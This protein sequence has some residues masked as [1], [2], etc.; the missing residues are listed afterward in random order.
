MNTR[1]PVDP[2]D[3][4]D[5]FDPVGWVSRLPLL[6][7]NGAKS[8]RRNPPSAQRGA[9]HGGLRAARQLRLNGRSVFSAANPPYESDYEPSRMLL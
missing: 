9:T 1:I 5:P 3:P 8:M 7:H 4:F 6:P 2:V